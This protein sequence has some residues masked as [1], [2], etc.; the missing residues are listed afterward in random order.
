LTALA[1]LP[2][3]LWATRNWA[4]G[5]GFRIATV[6]DLT[7]LYHMAG[8]SVSE[9]RGVDWLDNFIPR[10]EEMYGKPKPRVEPGDDVIAA[11]RSLAVDE[12]KARPG[13]AARVLVKSQVKLLVSH[14]LGDLCN[15]LA[16]HYQPSNLFARLVLGESAES[17]VQSPALLA[18]AL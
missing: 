13:A 18:A 7:L 2:S 10:C 11:A 8:Y 5:N 6:G 17:E 16:V 12:I 15:I 9:E 14:S 1:V 4:A 3:G